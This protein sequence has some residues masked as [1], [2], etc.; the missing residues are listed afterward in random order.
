MNAAG[1]PS[2]VTLLLHEN[3]LIL[4]EQEKSREPLH[5]V[6][7]LQ[8]V[9]LLL[10]LRREFLV[11]RTI[12]NHQL[13]VL[14]RVIL[15]VLG[16]EHFLVHL[17]APRAPIGPGE[18]EQDLLVVRLRYRDRLLIIRG[19]LLGHGA[20][21]AKEQRGESAEDQAGRM[22]FHSWIIA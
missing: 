2:E 5:V 16:I 17:D 10:H 8:A 18:I 3:L 14:R 9:V 1:P 12:D 4:V 19:P 7:L 15:E 22:G 20:G 21:C 13:Q 6:L 11:L